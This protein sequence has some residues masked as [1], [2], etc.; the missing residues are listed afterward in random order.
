MNAWFVV[1]AGLFFVFQFSILIALV[2]LYRRQSEPAIVNSNAAAN[3]SF[4][5]YCL[6]PQDA[7]IMSQ[8]A[9]KSL[10]FDENTFT[11]LREQ[12]RVIVNKT[13][14]LERDISEVRRMV[15]ELER[16][17]AAVQEESRANSSKTSLLQRDSSDMQAML[18]Q[19]GTLQTETRTISI[20]MSLLEHDRAT[21]KDTL[22]H[23][24]ETGKVLRTDL[25]NLAGSMQAKIHDLEQRLQRSLTRILIKSLREVGPQLLDLTKGLLPYF[26]PM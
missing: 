2:K 4:R 1:V 17:V 20:R 5:G 12:S 10:V 13:S 9:G 23:F 6:Q 15:R 14:L 22:Q 11:E 8:L 18:R 19:L 16:G 3:T 21:T 7:L 26:P 24:E 25:D